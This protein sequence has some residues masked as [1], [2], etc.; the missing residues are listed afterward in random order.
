MPDPKPRKPPPPAELDLVYRALFRHGPDVRVAVLAA[1]LGRRNRGATGRT[2]RA[3]AAEGRA[4]FK[5][6]RDEPAMYR[7]YTA[8]AV[9]RPTVPAEWLVRTALRCF[10]RGLLSSR[11]GGW[12]QVGTPAATKAWAASPE[13]AGLVELLG[14]PFV[15][16]EEAKDLAEQGDS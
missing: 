4:A 7:V 2:L 15:E 6:M 5:E 3:L 13:R 9:E 11:G 10:E 8:V 12:T 16:R 14:L 1:A